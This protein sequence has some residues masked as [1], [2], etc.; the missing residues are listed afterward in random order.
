MKPPMRVVFFPRDEIILEYG[1]DT[2]QVLQQDLIR[3]ATIFR[4]QLKPHGDAQCPLC[5]R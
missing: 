1:C 3:H 2:T 4:C 5:N